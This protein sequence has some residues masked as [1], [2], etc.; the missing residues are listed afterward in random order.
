MRFSLQLL[1]NKKKRCFG[2]KRKFFDKLRQDC[3]FFIALKHISMQICI[4]KVRS[5]LWFHWSFR[6]WIHYLINDYSLSLVC[7]KKKDWP[8]FQW[9]LWEKYSRYFETAQWKIQNKDH[10]RFLQIL[11]A[12]FCLQISFILM[13][14]LRLEEISIIFMPLNMSECY[15]A[16]L[17][18][19][20]E[21][22]SYFNFSQHFLP[23]HFRWDWKS[24][25]L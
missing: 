7:R 23:L 25:V 11:E 20:F 2:Y 12:K 21:K 1:K 9:N 24:I 6:W 10:S 16:I 19:K 17:F 22:K 13:L 15:S 18:Y 5:F 14:L 8:C 3:R 4:T